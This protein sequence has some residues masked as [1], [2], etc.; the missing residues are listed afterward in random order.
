MTATDLLKLLLESQELLNEATRAE[1]QKRLRNSTAACN[2]PWR[3]ATARPKTDTLKRPTISVT[4]ESSS[5]RP[6]HG[7]PC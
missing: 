7:R 6:N 4:S 5:S 3:A 1:N 2:R